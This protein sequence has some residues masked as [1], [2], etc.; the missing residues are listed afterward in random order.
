[1]RVGEGTFVLLL[2]KIGV[3]LSFV[4]AV[5]SLSVLVFKT[6]AFGKRTF[7]AEARSEGK[8]G[9]V[10]AFGRG[11]LPWEKESAA[12]HLPTYFAGI[13]YHTGIFAALIYLFWCVFSLNLPAPLVSIFRIIF[14][15]GFLSGIA[16]LL[17]RIALP[18]MRKI[19]CPDDFAA[20]VLVNLFVVFALVQTFSERFTHP[21]CL[22]AILM[23]LYLPVGKIR[24]C[25]FFFYTRIL[26]GYFYGRRGV[27][28]PPKKHRA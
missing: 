27:V 23:F 9:V 25:F 11:M 7:Y 14:V 15:I 21:F 8:K 24:H 16:L 5:I 28:P 6:F 13:L 17:K 18:V 2:L 10:Y 26:F 19:S 4:F 3:I 20:N 12:K 1:M 22:M